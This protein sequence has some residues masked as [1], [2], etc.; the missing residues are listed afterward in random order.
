MTAYE[1]GILHGFKKN[2]LE[3]VQKMYGTSD[4]SETAWASELKDKIDFNSEKFNKVEKEEIK[5]PELNKNFD[6]NKETNNK[7]K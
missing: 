1:F 5:M 3:V 2:D 6:S 7:K 4:L